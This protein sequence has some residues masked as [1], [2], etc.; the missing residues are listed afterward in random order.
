M[1]DQPTQPQWRGVKFGAQPIQRRS[2]LLQLGLQ[3]R[4][5]RLS[6]QALLPHALRRRH[7]LDI[8]LDAIGQRGRS[9]RV[10]QRL[11]LAV[12]R[13]KPSQDDP[14]FLMV[15]FERQW[16]TA[17]ARMRL[18]RLRI[19][20]GNAIV[21]QRARRRAV[22]GPQRQRGDDATEDNQ[23]R[24][25]RRSGRPVLERLAK[26]VAQR[27]G[28]WRLL[29]F[30]MRFDNFQ[31]GF[32]EP[33]LARARKLAGEFGGG[34]HPRGRS[35]EDVA[36]SKIE[37]P[38]L[39]AAVGVD[40]RGEFGDRGDKPARQFVVVAALC[41]ARPGRED[42]PAAAFKQERPLDLRRIRLGER[43][44]GQGTPRRQRP[45]AQP[46]HVGG[47]HRVDALVERVGEIAKSIRD[48]R[49]H[50]TPGNRI[51][52]LDHH[53]LGVSYLA[54]DRGHHQRRDRARE[55]L[56]ARDLRLMESFD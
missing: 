30:F 20:F 1:V 24:L 38:Q 21:A 46:P 2:G 10:E 18:Q 17:E 44:L 12:V 19:G 33:A 56:M 13:G 52:R 26:L 3:S 6:P 25:A 40:G 22:R 35:Q 27:G 15:D 16:K 45:K 29:V 36:G 39:A 28:A 42:A 8:A 11:R 51:E 23:G 7:R 9:D 54:L 14:L 5:P 49:G 4:Q 43:H 53:V 31:K 48:S 37:H 55:F 47:N 41:L 32:V 50:E 34:D